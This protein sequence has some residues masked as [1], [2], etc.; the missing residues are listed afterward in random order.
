MREGIVAKREHAE[1]VRIVRLEVS[2]VADGWKDATARWR[3]QQQQC[4]EAANTIWQRWLYWHISN[5]SANK[6]RA[7]LN[8][9]KA[10]KKAA[11]K[12]PVEAVPNKLANEIYHFCATAFPTLG[13]R[14]RVLLQ[15]KIISGIKSRKASS[16]SLPGWTAILLCHESVPSFTRGVPIPFDK[17]NCK[18][19]IGD[20]GELLIDLR[21][22]R[23]EAKKKGKTAPSITDR[24]VLWSKGKRVRSQVEVFKLV[25]T[26]EFKFCGSQLTYDNQ[27]RKWFVMLAYKR[28]VHRAAKLN[29]E[30][31]AYLL[32][33]KR[34]P[35]VL[36]FPEDRR[37]INLQ[38]DGTHIAFTR[39]R[40]TGERRA[41]NVNY[42][43]ATARKGK[44]FDHANRWRDDLSHVW[45]FFVRRVN[46]AVSHDAVR[47][48]VQHGYGKL[49]M[50][51]PE[52]RV[53]ETRALATL[54]STG[55]DQTTWEFFQLKTMLEYKS[56]D[57]G[58]E[59]SAVKA[60]GKGLLATGSGAS[61]A[62]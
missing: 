49:V 28:P 50:I 40:I 41:R 20:G 18:L 51:Q 2:T 52:G 62:A 16:G 39:K 9:R 21:T 27:H 29:P 59:F 10:D 11:G 6:I 55:R 33:G 4:R 19:S 3:E 44:G 8:A 57:V 32:P 14:V 12:C 24:I 60:D 42:R 54:G 35:F 25:L 38:D 45:S 1:S 36:W 47:E 13:S 48:C 5:N 26:G 46:H 56:Q 37:Y 58:V 23:D 22:F 43:R 30:K 34:V 17:D 7:W 15:N 31:T 53:S 61:V